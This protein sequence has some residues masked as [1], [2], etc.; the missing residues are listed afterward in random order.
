M[1]ILGYFFKFYTMKIVSMWCENTYSA[2][3]NNSIDCINIDFLRNPLTFY[4]KS[5]LIFICLSCFVVLLQQRKNISL[6]LL[7]LVTIFIGGFTFHLL[8]EGK[9]RYIIPYIVVLIPISCINI[10]TLKFNKY[11][12]NIYLKF[13]HHT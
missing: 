1:I 13:F 9:S 12:K 3:H 8:W 2:I 6:E 11:I 10:E 5:L 7:F 4:Q